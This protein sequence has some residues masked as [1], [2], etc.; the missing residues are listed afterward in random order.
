MGN[1]LSVEKRASR[2]KAFMAGALA[3]VLCLSVGMIGALVK[4]ESAQAARYVAAQANLDS[5]ANKAADTV[6]KKAKAKQ[7]TTTAKLKKIYRYIA[8]DKSFGGSFQIESVPYF[9]FKYGSTYYS[10]NLNNMKNKLVKKY[11]KKYASDMLK[12]K[13]GSCYHYASLFA[14]SAKKALG[15]KATVKIAVGPSKHT[16]EL[17][18]WHAWTEVTIGKK[19]Y[20]YDTQAGNNYS[21]AVSK[22]TDFGRFCGTLKS[23]LKANYSNYKGV[24]YTTVKL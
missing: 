5:A 19:T 14:V 2:T 21:K 10:A 11:Y 20:I 24:K 1:E 18:K 6:I 7:G 4:H 13:K 16:G 12:E 23:K 3:L 15:R 22:A 9:Y 8:K 17:N